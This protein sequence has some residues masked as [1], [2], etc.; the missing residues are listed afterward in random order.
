[1]LAAA[2]LFLAACDGG[3]AEPTS[4][5]LIVKIT[6]TGVEQDPD[7]YTLS[8]GGWGDTA[9]ATNAT[10]AADVPPGWYYIPQPLEGDVPYTPITLAGVAANCL[11]SGT[12]APVYVHASETDT[13]SF[14]VTCT[15][16]TGTLAIK[17]VTSGVAIDPDG[18]SYRIDGGAPTAVG[19]N[20]TAPATAVAVGAHG[21]TLSGVVMNCVPDSVEP[22]LIDILPGASDTLS[23]L[24]TCAWPRVVV[25]FSG[26]LSTGIALI[27]PDGTNEQAFYQNGTDGISYFAPAW[28]PGRTDIALQRQGSDETRGIGIFHPDS[29][30]VVP[31]L[32]SVLTHTGQRWSPSGDTLVVRR[33]DSTAA[34]FRAYLAPTN[35]SPVIPVTP[36]TLSVVSVDWAPNGSQIAFAA[37]GPDN[38]TRLYLIHPDGTGLARISP[39]SVNQVYW[40]RW[41]PDGDRVAF[42]FQS[43]LWT[44]TPA[45]TELTSIPI[46]GYVP[47]SPAAWSPLGDEFLL[48]GM[49]PVSGGGDLIRISTSG[50]I[51]ATL[52]RATGAYLNPDW[53]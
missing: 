3:P 50:A 32:T 51:H 4:A 2:S 10:L 52:T 30:G 6:T 20:A 26:G 40:P 24:V 9:V 49:N 44:I 28:S 43:M 53:R 34:Q 27:N 45:G 37:Q 1:M 23:I 22:Y 21:V 42:A 29:I 36:D 25:E 18:Y 41:S 31:L 33:Y 39:D 17:L 46:A 15:A 11:S 47:N 48:T 5:R 16:T 13:L 7:G 38:F 8:I 19:S 12:A 35:G 14:V